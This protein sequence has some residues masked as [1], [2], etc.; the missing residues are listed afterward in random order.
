MEGRQHPTAR[1]DT[2]KKLAANKLYVLARETNYF[3]KKDRLEELIVF[4]RSYSSVKRRENDAVK[5]SRR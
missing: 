3:K 1:V 2:W 4:R 5:E